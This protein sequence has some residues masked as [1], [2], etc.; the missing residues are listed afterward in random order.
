MEADWLNY[1]GS[2]RTK[3]THYNSQ[4]NCVGVA[5]ANVLKTDDEK[6]MLIEL[7]RQYFMLRVS[8]IIKIVVPSKQT[9]GTR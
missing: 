3:A 8:R 4:Q 2:M 7:V 1:M 6:E 9:I 5:M